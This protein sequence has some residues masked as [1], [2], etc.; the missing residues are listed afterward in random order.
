MIVTALK[1]SYWWLLGALCILSA[2]ADFINTAMLSAKQGY[3]SSAFQKDILLGEQKALSLL[4]DISFKSLEENEAQ[5]ME[6]QEKYNNKGLGFYVYNDDSLALWDNIE[7]LP[8]FYFREFYRPT[9]ISSENGSYVFFV[10]SEGKKHWVVALVLNHHYS[11]SNQY[12]QENSPLSKGFSKH[13]IIG[14]ARSFNT[15]IQ[16]QSGQ[17]ICSIEARNPK[18]AN[19][20]M[21][22]AVVLLSCLAAISAYGRRN[23]GFILLSLGVFLLSTHFI[24]P[25]VLMQHEWFRPNLYSGII[26]GKSFADA[27]VLSITLLSLLAT[28]VQRFRKSPIR[29]AFF[30]FTAALT[31]HLSYELISNSLIEVNTGDI[32][33]LDVDSLAAFLLQG[34]IIWYVSRFYESVKIKSHFFSFL[35]ILVTQILI[36][37]LF[38][39]TWWVALAYLSFALGDFLI[40]KTGLDHKRKVTITAILLIGVNFAFIQLLDE[41]KERQE[42]G[43]VVNKI[44]DKRDGVAEFLLSDLRTNLAGDEYIQ[45]FFTN[46]F[47]PKSSV[48]E[49]L[50]KIY[51]RGYL[52]KFDHEILFLPR[53]LKF[54]YTPDKGLITEIND[55]LTYNSEEIGEGLYLA[56]NDNYKS[57][58]LAEQYYIYKGDTVG[59]IL[60]MLNEKT[61]YDKSIYPELLISKEDPFKEFVRAYAVYDKNSLSLSKGNVNYP[62]QIADDADIVAAITTNEESNVEHRIFRPSE[63]TTYVVSLREKSLLSYLGAFSS[64]LFII[65]V[66]LGSFT[67][68]RFPQVF[69]VFTRTMAMRIRLVII[70]SVLFALLILAYA[71]ALFTSSNYEKESVDLILNKLKKAQLYFSELA[72]NN[73]IS[74]IEGDLFKENTLRFSELYETDI[75]LFNTQGELVSSSQQILYENGILE[76]MLD[77]LAY[78]ELRVKNRSQFLKPEQVGLLNYLSAF[79]PILKDKEVVGYI[80]LPYFA[81]QQDLQ[82]EQTEFFVALF[83]IYLL[84]IGL[85]AI[86]SALMARNLTKPLSFI[87][88]QLKKTTLTGHNEKL[89]WDRLDEIGLLVKEYNQMIDQ[90]E[91][92]AQQLAESKQTE[93]WKEMS[94]QVAHE[95]KNPLTPMKLNIQQL[96]RA[97]KDKSKHLD[98]QFD[99]VTSILIQQ[100]DILSKIASEFSSFA[101]MPDLKFEKLQLGKLLNDVANLYNHDRTIVSVKSDTP[102]TQLLGDADQFFRAINNIVKNG[103]QAVENQEEAVI[104]IEYSFSQSSG[105]VIKI[106]DNGKGISSTEKDR[107]FTPN[108]STKSSGMGLGLAIVK[109][110]IEQHHGSIYFLERHPVGT[111]FI[112]EIGPDS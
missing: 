6:L 40:S 21:G 49:R 84:L 98:K 1:R 2:G 105:I 10:K 82:Q 70:A 44:S 26:Y 67:A 93:A 75:D 99:K 23:W 62:L 69:K 33:G 86:V 5:F 89:E 32:M 56:L 94:R 48:E 15:V 57:T 7:I 19:N 53:R 42:L 90:L 16:L 55:I 95:I 73:G 63:E 88:N 74:S 80:R 34:S 39:I 25:A 14:G 4:E 71:T 106:S 27:I 24:A 60:L 47:L 96:Q 59:S 52:R 43:L 101:K 78:F 111:T 13:F 76:N 30:Y 72:S 46:P 64:Y 102:D 50:E 104:E 20:W 100:I 61:F 109:Q 92:S 107:I 87:T 79:S 29:K 58:Y 103:I 68:I 110:I 45:S 77:G 35:S 66:V 91:L 37:Y 12:L 8:P 51:I 22:Y 112:I 18:S 54:G 108:F 31:I 3:V 81:R 17:R 41:T 28:L 65:G 36:C 85:I 38:S 9:F 11:F 83:N 97:W